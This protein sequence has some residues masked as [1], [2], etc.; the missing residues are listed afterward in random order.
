MT[1]ER[2][3]ETC[4]PHPAAQGDAGIQLRH[5]KGHLAFQRQE[6]HERLRLDWATVITR[7][8]SRRH[9]TR[10]LHAKINRKGGDLEPRGRQDQPEQQRMLRRTARM[11]RNGE[12]LSG[13]DLHG[14]PEELRRRITRAAGQGRTGQA[15]PPRG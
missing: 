11:V 4:G 3:G 5:L 9:I 14:L 13:G 6:R 12:R 2:E 7:E 1:S 8:Q 15:R 10:D